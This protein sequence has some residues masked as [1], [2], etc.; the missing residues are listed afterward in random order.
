LTKLVIAAGLSAAALAVPAAAYA[1]SPHG[2]G[3]QPS[4]VAHAGKGHGKPKAEHKVTFVFRGTFTAPG[5]V[6]VRSGNAH[7][8][9]AGFIGKTVTFDL[10]RA[11]IVAADTNGDRAVDLLD[12]KDGD[13][14]LVQARLPRGTASVAGESAAAMAGTRLVDQSSPSAGD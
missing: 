6:T 11:R 2:A 7:V 14:V 9:R 5:A 4:A 13:R 3:H 10:S 8:R 12:V 1:H